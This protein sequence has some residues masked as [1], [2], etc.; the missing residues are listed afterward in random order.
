MIVPSRLF[1]LL[2][3]FGILLALAGLFVRGAELLLIPYNLV[4]FLA[5]W[6]TGRMAAKQDF[7]LVK[8]RVDP[9]LSVRVPNQVSLTVENQSDQPVE[10]MVRDEPPMGCRSTQHEF[11]TKLGA[12]RSK[13]FSYQI[14][15]IERG[16]DA[17]RG[18]YI[19]YKA[20]LGLA[21]VQ[22]KFDTDQPAR[23]YPNVLALREYEL[24]KQ[25]GH[26]EQ[27]GVRRSR[28][29]GLGTEFESLRDYNEDDIRIVD[30]KATSRRGKLVVKNFEQERNQAVIVCFDVGRHM[31]AQ[32]DG[33]RKLDYTLDAGLMLMY[34]A[35]RMGDQ[36]G[37]LVFNDQVKRWIAPK[38]G[39]HQVAAILDTIHALHAE[40]VQPDHIKAFG[41]L[42]SR[43]KRR[44]LIV[45]FTDAETKEDSQELIAALGPFA[46][47]HL[48]FIVR[49][50]DP[51]LRELQTMKVEDDRDFYDKAASL[52]Y[53]RDRRE[54][55][56]LLSVAGYQSIEAEPQELSGALVTAYLRVKEL[57]LI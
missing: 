9:I 11:R 47:R 43:W 12:D 34:A 44:S 8:R 5:L 23:I 6:L 4:L 26:L 49:V 41:Y 39:R 51:R 27:M 21:W 56:N 46:R 20:P 13:T 29:K 32:I 38:K 14:L 16:S 17:F 24:L 54:A 2:L 48:L 25:K 55:E 36:I 19:R 37:T 33:V 15:P 10:L 1:W 30:W 42:G 28:I 18:T 3:G 40:A 52:I 31:L 35:E 7:L 22:K 57:N 50:M 53:A 45:L